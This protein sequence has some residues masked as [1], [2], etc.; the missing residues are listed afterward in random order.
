MLEPQSVWKELRRS[1]EFWCVCVAQNV[2]VQ[3]RE[4]VAF[5]RAKDKRGRVKSHFY[6]THAEQGRSQSVALVCYHQSIT[7]GLRCVKPVRDTQHDLKG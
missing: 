1:V 5:Q 6:P 3:G 7:L 2:C 4:V